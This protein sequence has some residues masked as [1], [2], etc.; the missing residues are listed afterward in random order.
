MA[1]DLFRLEGQRALITGGATGIG[2]AIGKAFVEAGARIVMVGRRREV[3]EEAARSL[4]PDAAFRV[5]DLSKLAEIPPL[6]DDLEKEGGP[7]DILVNNAGINL[8][9]PALDLSDEEFDRILQT[10]LHGLFAITRAVLRP[11]VARKR[12]VILNISSMAAIYGLT[13]VAAYGSSKSAVTGLTRNLAAEFGAEGIRINSIAPGFIY[14]EMTAKALDSDPE[15]KKR[16][17][18]RTP[19]ARM[20]QASEIASAALF[21]CSEAAS[22]V[23]GVNLPVD[24]GNSIGF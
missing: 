1:K 3:L 11:M 7:F 9:K 23:T 10:N 20:G 18:D 14:S 22:F 16:V 15:R 17:F 5:C 8:K 13:K 21:L 6:I 4:G 12:G 19:M 2:L 24:G